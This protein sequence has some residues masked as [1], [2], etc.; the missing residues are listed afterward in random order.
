MMKNGFLHVMTWTNHERH[1]TMPHAKKI[2]SL[3]M[4]LKGGCKHG[5]VD[6]KVFRYM[7][8]IICL[9]KGLKILVKCCLHWDFFPRQPL[10]FY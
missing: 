5:K 7:K 10:L 9:V 4:W 1:A 8:T 2:E 6:Q 3:I